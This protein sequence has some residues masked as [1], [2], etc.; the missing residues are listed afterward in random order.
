M[1]ETK[2]LTYEAPTVIDAD[3]ITYKGT[4]TIPAAYKPNGTFVSMKNATLNER[5]GVTLSATEV[6]TVW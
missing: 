3:G 1:E 5:M 6:S 2:Q 4:K